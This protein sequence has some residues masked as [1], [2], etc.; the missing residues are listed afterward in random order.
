MPLFFVLQHMGTRV[1]ILSFLMFVWLTR[2]TE[3][4]D[5]DEPT[6]QK[7]S[8]DEWRDKYLEASRNLAILHQQY[9][10]MEEH[11]KKEEERKIEIKYLEEEN[12]ELKHALRSAKGITVLLIPF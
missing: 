8:K 2:E 9:N 4:D 3:D 11:R 12:Q 1:N 6:A 10:K 7:R 5:E